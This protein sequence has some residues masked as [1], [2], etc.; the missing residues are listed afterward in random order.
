[1]ELHTEIIN[2]AEQFQGLRAEWQE[3]LEQSRSSTIFLS[4]EWLANWWEVYGARH[5]LHVVTARDSS[6]D[7]VGAAPLKLTRKRVIGLLDLTVAG[8]IGHGEDVVPEY[9]D[10]VVRSGLEASVSQAMLKRLLGDGRVQA[11]DLKPFCSTS[12]NLPWVRGQLGHRPG[13]SA[14]LPF[15]RCPIIRL[16]DSWEAYLAGKS[17]NFRKKL[18]EYQRRCERDWNIEI[19]RSRTP[20]EL[21]RDLL[22]LISTHH[23]RWLGASAAFSS[24]EYIRFHTALS[25]ALLE[26]DRLRLHIMSHE[27]RP[28]AALYCFKYGNR[29]YY[30]QSGR[31][32][33]YAKHR[34]GFVLLQ[35]AIKDAIQDGMKVFD[36]LTGT[37]EYKERWADAVAD[38]VRIVYTE[39]VAYALPTM[40]RRIRKREPFH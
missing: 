1:M 4:W 22:H 31:D 35:A 19:R 37:E 23:K 17:R 36:L 18:R 11:L 30:Y 14:V 3:L 12:P 39:S 26:R 5:R 28:I 40:L 15:S 34:V 24:A 16:P 21:H 6:G 2:T 13:Y 29:Y 9:L 7:L 38:S 20:E 10:F 27:G 32:P 8:F 33:K 25:A